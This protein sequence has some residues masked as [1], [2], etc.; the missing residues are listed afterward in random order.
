MEDGP[1]APARTLYR[2]LGAK[3]ALLASDE[4]TAATV[5]T[6]AGGPSELAVLDAKFKPLH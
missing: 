2:N 6:F 4:H 5:A 1:D 3:G